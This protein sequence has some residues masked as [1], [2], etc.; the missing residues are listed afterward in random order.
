V[1]EKKVSMTSIDFHAPLRRRLGDIR[2]DVIF[3]IASFGVCLDPDAA[4]ALQ[5]HG[6]PEGL[7]T[8]QLAHA[9]FALSMV[10][11]AY[12]LEVNRFTEKRGWRLIQISCLLFFL[13]N[14]VAFCGHFVEVR[15]PSDLIEGH[16]TGWGQRLIAGGGSYAVFYYFLKMDHL[17]CVP[18]I[19]CLFLGIRNLYKQTLLKAAEK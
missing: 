14:V 13:W 6:S 7:Y 17:V 15:I 12:W 3:L 16:G 18:A 9:L 5:S 1:N 19:L 2:F 4:W 8:H 10:G 11:L